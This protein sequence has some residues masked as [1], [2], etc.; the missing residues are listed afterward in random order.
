[1]KRVS[2]SLQGVDFYLEERQN[3]FIF[4]VAMM[5]LCVTFISSLMTG[6][7]HAK[8]TNDK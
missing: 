5:L 2:A 3:K 6:R 8:H 4:T 7:K 1:M